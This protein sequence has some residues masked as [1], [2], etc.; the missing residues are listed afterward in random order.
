MKRIIMLCI[1]LSACG[2]AMSAAQSFG[3]SDFN[4]ADWTVVTETTGAGGTLLSASQVLVGGNPAAHRQIELELNG[5]A[6][7]GGVFTHSFRT[8]ATYNPSVEGAIATLDYREDARCVVSSPGGCFVIG[9]SLRQDGNVFLSRKTPL[10]SISEFEWTHKE[11]TG[12]TPED[13]RSIASG[14]YSEHPDFSDSGSEI[15]FG[16]HRAMSTSPVTIT[17]SSAIDNWEIVLHQLPVDLISF[18]ISTL[19]HIQQKTESFQEPT[20]CFTQ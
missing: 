8:S 11:L 1:I 20:S 16:F 10:L 4:D 3:D 5:S 2:C 9:P 15:E 19:Y 12:L 6:Q 18:E 17:R 7:G 14:N 13:F